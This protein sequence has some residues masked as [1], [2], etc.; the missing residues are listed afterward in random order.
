MIITR[1]KSL[2]LLAAPAII[3]ARA[4]VPTTHA[5]KGAPGGAGAAYVGPG[6]VVSGAFVWGGFRAYNAAYTTGTKSLV[7]L[8]DQSGA[9]PIT[10][11]CLSTGKFDNATYNAWVTAHSVTT[12]HISRLYD[13]TGNAR[14]WTQATLGNMPVLSNVGPNTEY[15]MMGTLGPWLTGPNITLAQ[16]F[17]TFFVGKFDI[18]SAGRWPYYGDSASTLYCGVRGGANTAHYSFGIE[19]GVT[20]TTAWH[21]HGVLASGVSS[22]QSLDGATP[23]VASGGT[24]AFTGTNAITLLTDGIGNW[25]NNAGFAEI[26]FWPGDQSANFGALNTNAHSATNGW[27]F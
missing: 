2:L 18:S 19:E 14:H 26:G 24:A 25:A 9:N 27:N 4:Q 22:S 20:V 11:N 23:T 16:A 13:Q 1:R 12:T 5:G 3:R 15:V 6:D 10:I 21:T 8:V 17:T 7:D